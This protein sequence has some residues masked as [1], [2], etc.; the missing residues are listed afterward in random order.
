MAKGHRR[1]PITTEYATAQR[2]A[3]QARTRGKSLAYQERLRAELLVAFGKLAAVEVAFKAA[4]EAIARV[5]HARK[6]AER[7]R[8]L[9]PV[10]MRQEVAAPVT[11]IECA[12]AKLRDALERLD[13]QATARASILIGRGASHDDESTLIAQTLLRRGHSIDEV[14][15]PESQQSGVDLADSAARARVR[16]A[17]N[18]VITKHEKTLAKWRSQREQLVGANPITTMLRRVCDDSIAEIKAELARYRLSTNG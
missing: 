16:R 8:D 15:D 7:D 1:K 3:K 5:E 14:A 13:D 6:W 2:E 11:D 18:A 10:M 17:K 12:L 9:L 4:S